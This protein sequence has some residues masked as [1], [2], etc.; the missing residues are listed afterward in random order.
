MTKKKTIREK[1]VNEKEYKDFVNSIVEKLK[2][3]NDKG[4]FKRISQEGWFK[5]YAIKS[6]SQ[7]RKITAKVKKGI[8]LGWYN[9]KG[10]KG[11]KPPRGWMGTKL[12]KTPSKKE[13]KID[14]SKR[15]DDKIAK[16]KSKTNVQKLKTGSKKYPDASYY[17][18]LH[19]VNSKTSQSYRERHGKNKEY[20]GRIVLDK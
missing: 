19:G 7:F 12:G 17:E 2:T 11:H 13:K 18:L 20:S 10:K 16:S 6:K 14:E 8:K 15:F 9:C 3:D 5:S 1:P 4:A